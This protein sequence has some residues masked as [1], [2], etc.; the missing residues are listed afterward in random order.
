MSNF[1][2][3]Q[4]I[5][6]FRYFDDKGEEVQGILKV[7]FC[8]EAP[9]PKACESTVG[10]S[11]AYFTHL[12]SCIPLAKDESIQPATVWTV[13][14]DGGPGVG[15]KLIYTGDNTPFYKY[16]VSVVFEC[17]ADQDVNMDGKYSPKYD[18]F[19]ISV[20]TKYSCRQKIGEITMVFHHYRYLIMAVCMVLG[21]FTT[22][23][24]IYKIKKTLIVFGFVFTFFFSMFFFTAI[25][26]T[27]EIISIG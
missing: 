19:I 26:H 20:R 9:K 6:D 14:N 2:S 25:F 24:G 8:K 4:T 23:F 1:I 15:E 10:A 5:E 21:L 22:Y 12:E 16:G 17:D 11:F 3:S 13:T 18:I 27:R 7:D